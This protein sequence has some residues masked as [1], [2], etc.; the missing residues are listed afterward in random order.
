MWS[1]DMS[2]SKGKVTEFFQRVREEVIPTFDRATV[3]FYGVQDEGIAINR[4]GV[5][6]RI[7]DAGFI[8]TASHRLREKVQ[9]SIPLYASWNERTDLP[10]PLHDSQFHTTDGNSRC[11]ERYVVVHD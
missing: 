5:L 1:D 2:D 7:A 9:K 6:L 4:T 8:L 10:I 11:R 3:A